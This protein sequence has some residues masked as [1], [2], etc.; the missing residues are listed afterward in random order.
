MIIHDCQQRSEEWHKLRLGRVTG[1]RFKELMTGKSATVKNLA[2]KVAAER[3]TGK[4]ADQPFKI[5][6]AMEQGIEREDEALAAFALEH[7]IKVEKAGFLEYDDL[8]GVSP[9]GVIYDN[10]K[11]YRGV[12][13]KC[14]LPG[15]FLGYL[16]DKDSLL[17]AYKWQVLSSLWVSGFDTWY[18]AA[19]C[20]EFNAET[21]LITIPVSL[22]GEDEAVINDK[23]KF[24]RN[25]VDEILKSFDT[26]LSK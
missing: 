26:V 19:Y 21:R 4:S 12:E 18:L 17:K 1:T 3:I 14:P 10:G 24:F 6:G 13:V 16:I 9:D 25:R 7:L 11:P 5:S 8:L 22:S 23:V 20:P 2:Q 15:T